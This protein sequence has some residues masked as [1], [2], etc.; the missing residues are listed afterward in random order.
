[1]CVWKCVT[2]NLNIHSRNVEDGGLN[3]TALAL[4]RGRHSLSTQHAGA[5]GEAG[6]KFPLLWR[7]FLIQTTRASI[8]ASTR[9][10]KSDFKTYTKSNSARSALFKLYL[11]AHCDLFM[12]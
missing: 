12:L 7:R 3:I 5:G 1:M 11:P 6:L 8:T 9:M 10:K 2:A 4:K